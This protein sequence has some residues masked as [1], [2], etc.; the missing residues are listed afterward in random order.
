MPRFVSKSTDNYVFPLGL[1]YISSSLKQAGF[2]VIALNLN[3]YDDDVSVVLEKAIM[4]NGINVLFT[5]GLSGQFSVIRQ[6]VESTKKIDTKIITVVGGGLVSA[7]PDIA[8]AALVYADFGVIGEGEIT[9]VEL[10]QALENGGDPKNV[11]GIIYKNSEEGNFLITERRKEIA[12]IDSIPWPDY[13]GFELEKNLSNRAGIFGFGNKRVLF[14]ITSRSCPYSCT[15]CFHTTGKKYRKRNLDDFFNELDYLISKYEISAVSLS[16][17]LFASDSEHVRIFCSRIKKY[18]L[19]WSASFRVDSITPEVIKWIVETNNCVLLL[20]GLESAD[21]RILKSMNKKITIEQI[22]SALNLCYKANLPIM[23]NFIFG[24]IE[25]TV[26]TSEISLNWLKNNQKKFGIRVAHVV[27]HPGTVIYN[28]AC[29]KN[30]IKDKIKFLNDGCPQ[31]NISKMTDEEYNVLS[32][33]IANLLSKPLNEPECYEIYNFN[34][35][36]GCI[37]VKGKCCICGFENDWKEIRLFQSALMTCEQCGQKYSPPISDPVLIS[38]IEQNIIWILNKYKKIA[39][40]GMHDNIITIFKNSHILHNSNIFPVDN[41]PHK[42]NEYLFEKMV[43]SPEIITVESIPVV[44]VAV[45]TFY[46]II[47]STIEL[48]QLHVKRII[49]ISNLIGTTYV[50]GV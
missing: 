38:H 46:G 47:K 3:H 1:P 10:C 30:L 36:N 26:E 42:Q 31:T 8:I 45:P 11:Q 23:G 43:Y 18:N 27:A 24:D 49:D 25:E 37:S 17:E 9:C 5:G 29:Q 20:F 12:D 14:I 33:K 28:Y 22:E 44:V 35:K 13:E 50:T 2:D 32:G 4:K 40:W 15:F 39:I 7:E 6:V 48:N 21:N 41:S 34:D 19:T 16:D